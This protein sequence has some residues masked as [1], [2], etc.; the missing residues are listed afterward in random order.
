LKRSIEVASEKGASTWSVIYYVSMLAANG[1][2]LHKGVFWDSLCLRY[3]RVG[4][5]S[6]LYPMCVSG[7][8]FGVDD[9]SSFLIVEL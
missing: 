3:A 5:T 8:E 9:S 7:E 2:A 4:S 1:F 6:P